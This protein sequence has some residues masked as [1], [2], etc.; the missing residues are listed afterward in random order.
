MTKDD[1]YKKIKERLA[2]YERNISPDEIGEAIAKETDRAMRFCLRMGWPIREYVNYK[3]IEQE[4]WNRYFG[5]ELGG[6]T[7]D[8]LRRMI[9]EAE[10]EGQEEEEEKK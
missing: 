8:E 1:R 3:A 2:F 10:A 5:G 9:K 4:V 7:D 6:M